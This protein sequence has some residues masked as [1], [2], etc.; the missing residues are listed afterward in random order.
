MGALPWEA[1]AQGGKLPSLAPLLEKTIPAVVHIETR[2]TVTTTRRNPFPFPFPFN[3]P[4]PSQKRQSGSGSGV[5]F[6][7]DE[8][9]IITN[10]HVI[11]K[12]DNISVTLNDGRNYEATVIGKDPDTDIALLKI[13]ADNL[14]DIAFADSDQLRVGDFV[15]AIGN[16][17]GLRQTVTSGI[18]SGLGRSGLGIESYE[19]FIQTDASINPGNSGG[20]LINLH[21]ELVGINTAIFGPGG[22]I[23]IGFA[24]PSNMTKNVVSHLQKYGEVKRGR[25]GVAI[26]TL[27]RDLAEAF[28]VDQ[29]SGVII[30]SIEPGSAAEQA[31]LK[32]GDIVLAINGEP[33]E[34]VHDMRNFIGLLRIGTTINLD[35]L[36]DGDERRIRASINAPKI[37]ED[38]GEKYH[39]RLRGTLLQIVT[40]NDEPY[41]KA[42]LL[43]KNINP[44]SFAYMN[45]LRRGDL[46]TEVNQQS[47]S[48][49]QTLKAAVNEDKPLLLQVSR[50]T[51][52]AFLILR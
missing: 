6:D 51:R 33:V 27:T 32:P 10:S 21:G 18:V 13:D 34:N 15:I 30:T 38:V 40:K 9:L 46:I 17:F 4:A 25:L 43:V 12:A 22:N 37:T 8:G 49:F 39:S 16:P 41:S 35:I 20:A 2:A 24:I 23:G 31:K 26:Q 28:D 11:Q 48:S 45:G 44:R 42:G 29:T 7:A 19:D 52:T 14:I 36:R 47:V 3:N 5:I 50:G 1:T